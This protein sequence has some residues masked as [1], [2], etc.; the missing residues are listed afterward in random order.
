MWPISVIVGF[1]IATGMI[2]TRSCATEVQA[3]SHS[4][5]APDAFTS[6][7]IGAVMVQMRRL[8]IASEEAGCCAFI[9]RVRSEHGYYVA[10]YL[11]SK[12]QGVEFASSRESAFFR[13]NYT[14][15]AVKVIKTKLRDYYNTMH[16]GNIINRRLLCNCDKYEEVRCNVV[17][18][19]RS[20]DINRNMEV[21]AVKQINSTLARIL[22]SKYSS[23]R[24]RTCII[25]EPDAVAKVRNFTS[26]NPEVI[27]GDICEIKCRVH[28]PKVFIAAASSYAY[29][30]YQLIRPRSIVT[31]CGATKY[32]MNNDYNTRLIVVNGSG[33]LADGCQWNYH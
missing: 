15:V 21:H 4:I 2:S 30:I 20:G 25:T 19:Y 3:P 31:T 9:P 22:L 23:D 29:L 12:C 33:E 28:R 27:I 26:S 16:V 13:F 24:K 6:E 8:L 1:V 7:G 32:F 17:L 11:A 10:D 5:C 18:H 14:D